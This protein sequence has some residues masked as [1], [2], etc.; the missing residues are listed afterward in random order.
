MTKENNQALT[1]DKKDYMRLPFEVYY[2]GPLS[3]TSYEFKSYLEVDRFEDVRAV[4]M[5][6]GRSWGATFSCQDNKGPELYCCIFGRHDTAIPKWLNFENEDDIIFNYS[7]DYA[8]N[9]E[10]NEIS[11]VDDDEIDEIDDMSECC[12]SVFMEYSLEDESP[13]YIILD[14]D[15]SRVKVN[16]DGFVLDENGEIGT[17]RI[18]NPE[19]LDED[20]YED[21]S[22]LDM[23]EA[24]FDWV[25]GILERDFSKDTKLKLS[26]NTE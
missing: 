14:A 7:T 16:T 23:W 8:I 25:K 3:V 11:F 12:S 21:Y 10:N 20:E 2:S 22:T 19:E 1:A 4:H 24:K 13:D 6:Q 5:E 9:V 18:F 15:G 17:Q 26:F